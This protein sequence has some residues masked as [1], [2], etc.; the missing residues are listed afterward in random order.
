MADWLPEERLTMHK[1]RRLR[2]ERAMTQEELAAA[3][4]VSPGTITRLERF[5]EKP[6]TP[7]TVRKLAAALG[8]P[9]M[10]LTKCGSPLA[11][12]T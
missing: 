11:S 4:S 9:V 3:A 7:S 10:T 12:E 6:A 1:L 8:V 5:P 2:L